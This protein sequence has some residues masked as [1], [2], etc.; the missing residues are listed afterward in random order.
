MKSVNI[1]ELKNRLSAYLS[2]VKSG[3][4]IL[5][6]DRNNPIAK[7]VPIIRSSGQDE[8]LI[9][10][11]AKGKLRMGEGEMDDSF[12]ELPAPRISAAALRRSLDQ[13]RDEA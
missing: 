13:E 1:A 10:L 11:A 8:E 9:A 5:V 4:E 6:R 7:I 12:W 2:E 3:E